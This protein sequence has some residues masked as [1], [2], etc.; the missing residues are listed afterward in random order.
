MTFIGAPWKC[1]WL[2]NWPL[3]LFRSLC[4]HY[5]ETFKGSVENS[6]LTLLIISVKRW[7]VGRGHNNKRVLQKLIFEKSLR[8]EVCNT[9]TPL[10]V[11]LVDFSFPKPGPR[12]TRH[13]SRVSG[14]FTV[15]LFPRFRVRQL[16][17]FKFRHSRL[18]EIG[19]RVRGRRGPCSSWSTD[20][21]ALSAPPA[22]FFP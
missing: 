8:V 14:R 3:G 6:I 16:T 20:H 9:K 4:E 10:M 5:A 18:E 17:S 1:I 7:K 21:A 2:L 12:V 19:C 15:K 11:V 13:V 22:T